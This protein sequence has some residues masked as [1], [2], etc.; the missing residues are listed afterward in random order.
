MHLSNVPYEMWTYH[1]QRTQN[2]QIHTYTHDT[3]EIYICIQ[4]DD[5]LFDL[6]SIVEMS[7]VKFQ[8]GLIKIWEIYHGPGS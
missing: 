4:V 2:T 8:N 1:A 3:F 6:L 7:T 5:L